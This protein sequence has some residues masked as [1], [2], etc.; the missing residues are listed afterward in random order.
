M[1]VTKLVGAACL[2]ASAAAELQ[3]PSQYPY[4][5][6]YFGEGA[7]NAAYAWEAHKV[8]TSTGYEKTLF[9]LT[10]NKIF[11]EPEGRKHPILFVSGA[12]SNSMSH[13]S[14]IWGFYPAS[15]F[16]A[17]QE[18]ALKELVMSGDPTATYWL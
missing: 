5:A 10:G 17:E 1:F 12:T 16:I 13:V 9:R 15:A 2:A 6:A 4:F 3:D 18:A 11:P 8:T 7:E 14:P